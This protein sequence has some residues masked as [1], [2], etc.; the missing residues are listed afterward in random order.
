MENENARAQ[1]EM[2][3][4]HNDYT[5]IAKHGVH[6]SSMLVKERVGNEV[7]ETWNLVLSFINQV[8]NE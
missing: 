7:D 3:K 8:K 5:Y 2:A 6:G 1:F 4:E